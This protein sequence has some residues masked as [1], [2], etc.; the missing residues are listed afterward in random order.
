MYT[1]FAATGH[2]GS[3]VAH[4]LLDAGAAVRVVSR[5][6][7]RTT[8]FTARGAE[9]V[10]GDLT[11]PATAARAL[12]G[13]RGAF[14]VAPPDLQAADLLA[15][16][17]QIIDHYAAALATHAV[18][19]AVFL[20]SVGADRTAGTGPTLFARHAELTL[21]TAA[22]ATRFSFLRAPYFMDNL[23]ALAPALHAGVL[24]VFGGDASQ[25]FPMIAA[26]DLGALAA[27]ALLDP[28]AASELLEA[29]G[30]RDH[31]YTDAAALAAS[32][33]GHPV[34]PL[35]IPLTE[36]VPTLTRYGYSASVAGLFRELFEA[37]ARGEI[38]YENRGRAVRGTTELAEVLAALRDLPPPPAA[39]VAP[40]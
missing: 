40:R 23:L 38:R 6:A 13:A 19:H 29:R 32:V 26:R 33:L 25:P 15:R 7:T 22:P 30:P 35:M 39:P 5:D 24:P 2:T 16:N 36:V 11:D 1:V 20:S 12:A 34:A 17:R 21:P 8:P 37:L 27:A 4:R 28:P 14:L 10:I 31:S 3:I 18:P 9:A